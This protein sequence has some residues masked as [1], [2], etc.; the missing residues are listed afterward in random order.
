MHFFTIEEHFQEKMKQ[1]INNNE[2]MK[3]ILVRIVAY[4]WENDV[5]LWL[6]NLLKGN[7]T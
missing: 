4:I 5:P 1:E 6:S 2:Q 7:Q 3:E